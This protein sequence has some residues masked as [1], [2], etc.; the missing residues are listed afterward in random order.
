MRSA[1]EGDTFD[2][3]L[4]VRPVVNYARLQALSHGI[5][6][7]GTLT[8][9]HRLYEKGILDSTRHRSTSQIFEYLS[10]M[11]LR[12]QYRR[13]ENGY[14]PDNSLVL[15]ELSELERESLHQLLDQIHSLQNLIKREF[16]DL[17]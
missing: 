2:T 4:G 9:L 14:P 10:Q 6:E 8:R 12:H 13:I 7:P 5:K 17:S 16:K 15:K 1:A 11:R 3:K